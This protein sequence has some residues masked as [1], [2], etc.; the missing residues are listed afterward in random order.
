MFLSNEPVNSV[1]IF[2]ETQLL[3]AMWEDTSGPVIMNF[4]GES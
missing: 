3:I 1:L 4:R 2:K